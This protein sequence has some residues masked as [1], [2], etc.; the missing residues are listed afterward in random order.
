[1][2]STQQDFFASLIYIRS[3]ILQGREHIILQGRLSDGRNYG[4]VQPYRPRFFIPAAW[5]SLAEE[6][7]SRLQLDM[8]AHTEEVW[9][10]MAGTSLLRI[11]FPHIR[12]LQTMHRSLKQESIPCYEGDIPVTQQFL[13]DH[14]IPLF[15]RFRG[16]PVP[17]ERVDIRFQGV[18]LVDI[19][20][21]EEPVEAIDPDSA[22]QSGG[23]L[24]EIRTLSLDIETTRDGKILCISL[25]GKPWNDCVLMLDRGLATLYPPDPPHKEPGFSILSY[26]DETALLN[27]FRENLLTMDPDIITGWNVISF[28]MAVILRRMDQL[29]VPGD[30]GR[31]REAALFTPGRDDFPDMADLPGRLVIDA[32]KLQRMSPGHFDSYSLEHVANRLLGTGKTE[33]FQSHSKMRELELLWDENPGEFARYCMEDARL[34]LK[35]LDANGLL[36]IT[37]QRSRLCGTSLSRSWASI[38]SFEQLYINRLHRMG[39]AAA[40]EDSE[41]L[42][43]NES[44]GGTIIFPRS[45]TARRVLVLDFKGLY[46]S[47]IRTFQVD[48]L[49]HA[50]WRCAGAALPQGYASWSEHLPDTSPWIISPNGAGFSRTGGILPEL[51][52]RFYEYREKAK[53]AGDAN[54]AYAYKILANSFYGVLGSPGCRFA[55]SDLAT[56]ITGFA[57]EILYWSRDRAEEHG[58]QVIYGD[59][60]SL[61]LIPPEDTA[62]SELEPRGSSFA[63][64]LNTELADF[65]R[66]EYGLVSRLEIE[67]ESIFA[68]LFIPP[69]KSVS[70]QELRDMLESAGL[71]APQGRAK[72]YAGIAHE[73]AAFPSPDARLVIKGMEAV[74]RDWT[75]LARRVQE[76]V[77]KLIFSSASREAILGYIQSTVEGM[78]KQENYQQLIISRRLS[79]PASGYR[80]S[81][82]P[83]VRA[84]RIAEDR[85]QP[86]RPLKKIRYVMTGEGPRPVFPGEN[87]PLPVPDKQWYIQKQILPV[88]ESISAAVDWDL[89]GSCMRRYDPG[90]QMDLWQ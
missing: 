38:H 71:D 36:E 25:S 78:E 1:M 53:K 26:A 73:P 69:L 37:F 72:S 23:G 28:D 54:A 76:D 27:G 63:R 52:D 13:I 62:D 79:K 89:H 12:Q 58:F 74:R 3:R 19:T 44:P 49:A 5:K 15:Y 82:P 24:P 29:G 33:K 40:D 61:F 16:V 55:G 43:M 50:Q 32:M 35:I 86:D 10:N 68:P 11:S 14:P 60:D 42:E 41:R 21:E 30:L 56:S 51:L 4:T 90:G 65:I 9:H 80:E 84:A 45:G 46:P 22:R 18:D 34:V 83:H 81:A 31:S 66:E 17:G 2:S 8:T 70:G 57:R 75:G 7:A 77:L 39:I 6:Q 64:W 88:L 87:I 67:F 20:L 48:P 59:T 47:I 85:I